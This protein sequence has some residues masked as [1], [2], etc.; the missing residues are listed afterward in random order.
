VYAEIQRLFKGVLEPYTFAVPGALLSILL[1]VAPLPKVGPH[2]GLLS[3][4]GDL[5]LEL[6]VGPER[7]ALYALGE[8]LTVRPPTSGDKVTLLC[9]GH[10]PLALLPAADHFEIDNP[11]GAGAALSFAAVWQNASGARAARFQF[12][13]ADASTFHDHRPYHGGMVGMVGERHMELAVAPVGTESEIQLYVTDA[14]RQPLSLEGLHATASIAGGKPFPLTVSAGCFVGRVARPKGALDVHTEVT[15]PGERAPLTMDFYLEPPKPA[16][17]PQKEP[18]EIRVGA[19]GFA[20]ARVEV[21]AEAPLR[22]RFLRTSNETC[23][24]QVVFPSL[25]LTRDLPLNQPVD[26]EVVPPRG[27]LAFT[28]GM[29]MFRGAVVGL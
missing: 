23:G 15:L 5:T 12:S 20:P 28:C 8:D 29:R 2:Q 4:A 25:G 11:Y 18:I 14:Y 24:K 19:A 26:I 22:L 17:G 13:P 10:P 1:T 9:A 3:A 27:E 7:L 16:R 6:V 21:S